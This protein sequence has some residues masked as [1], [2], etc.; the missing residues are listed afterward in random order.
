MRP[1]E[2]VS[3]NLNF[4]QT[5][6]I[7]DSPNEM[8]GLW[9]RFYTDVLN[10]YSPVTDMKIKGN[11]LPY[12]IRQ[13]DYL[14]GKANKTKYLRQAH[15]QIRSGVYCMIRNLRKT[16]HTRNIEESKGDMKST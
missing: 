16:Y 6:N 5:K 1:F 3:K 12:M 13:R 2:R 10:E 14:R 4:E 8:W 9:E 7:T 15:Q 11:N